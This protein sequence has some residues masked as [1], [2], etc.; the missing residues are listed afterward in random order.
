LREYLAGAIAGGSTAQQ[1][2]DG[3]PPAQP[4]PADQRTLIYGIDDVRVLPD[5]RVAA[6]VIGD[7]LSKPNPPGPALIYF[8]EV[9]GRWL[10]DG[11]V[12]TEEIV[13]PS[14]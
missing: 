7:D 5:G 12:S 14:P 6:L 8:V 2:L 3:L 10:G 1:I 9:D 13:T 4:L 11:F